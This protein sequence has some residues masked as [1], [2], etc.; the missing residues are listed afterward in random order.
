[1]NGGSALQQDRV[2]GLHP[3]DIRQRHRQVQGIGLQEDV[4]GGHEGKQ[5]HGRQTRLGEGLAAQE[6]TVP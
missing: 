1:V 2:D 4:C 5:Q 3:S 6:R